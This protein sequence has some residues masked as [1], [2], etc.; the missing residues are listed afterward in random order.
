MQFIAKGGRSMREKCVRFTWAGR[1]S[2][3]Y[4]VC[5]GFSVQQWRTVA[6]A[7]WFTREKALPAT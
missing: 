4:A 5:G 2:R 3:V 7:S 1:H 6:K